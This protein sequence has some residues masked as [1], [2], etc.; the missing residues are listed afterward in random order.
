MPLQALSL[1]AI[2]AT[3]PPKPIAIYSSLHDTSTALS[4]LVS[5]RETIRELVVRWWQG[6]R[7]FRAREEATLPELIL[8]RGLASVGLTGVIHC[9]GDSGISND[10]KYTVL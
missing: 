3:G 10:G 2:V 9:R 6:V 5:D 4:E 1:R 8:R 7:R